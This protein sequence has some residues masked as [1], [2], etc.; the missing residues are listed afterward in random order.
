MELDRAAGY[1]IIVSERGYQVA[2]RDIRGFA[3]RQQRLAS[4]FSR[5]ENCPCRPV[6]MR[7][8]TNLRRTF[9]VD[10]EVK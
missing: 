5:V 3:C 10:A 6:G 4:L 2:L 8:K 9:A 7:M 1:A